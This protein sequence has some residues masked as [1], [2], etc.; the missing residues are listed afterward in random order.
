MIDKR[1]HRKDSNKFTNRRSLLLSSR[2][3]KLNLTKSLENVFYST[4]KKDYKKDSIK[5]F[6]SF[7]FNYNTLDINRNLKKTISNI[8]SHTNSPYKKKFLP[9]TKRYLMHNEIL[10][11]KKS[12]FPIRHKKNI[13]PLGRLPSLNYFSFTKSK[14]KSNTKANRKDYIINVFYDCIK[15]FFPNV[16]NLNLEYNEYEIFRNKS[17]Y[18]N[19]IKDKINYF[20]K[21]KNENQSI[22]LEKNFYY[23]KSKKEIDLTLDSMIISFQDMSLPNDTQDKYTKI[24][25]PFALLPIF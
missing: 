18:D 12:K 8:F 15:E 17:V 3:P 5:N 19:L 23:G 11:N 24:N 9:L 16:Y 1:I 14:P 20:K 6:K 13:K 4:I 7:D 2:S 21:N 25:F 10:N 22:K